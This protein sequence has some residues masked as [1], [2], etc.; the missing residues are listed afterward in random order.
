MQNVHVSNVFCKGTKSWKFLA[1]I[2]PSAVLQAPNISF[3]NLYDI[4]W[5]TIRIYFFWKV[6]IFPRRADFAFKNQSFEELKLHQ[7]KSELR[8][9]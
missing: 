8:V 7:K 4:I 2:L 1:A 3:M 9:W 6:D 5:Y